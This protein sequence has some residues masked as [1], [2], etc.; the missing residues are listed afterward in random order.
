MDDSASVKI[1]CIKINALCC[2]AVG[3]NDGSDDDSDSD[4]E[5]GTCP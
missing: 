5:G 3:L 1:K 2:F 4:D